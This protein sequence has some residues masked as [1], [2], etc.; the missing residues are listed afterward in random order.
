M[1]GVKVQSLFWY[2]ILGTFK[3]SCIFN[4]TLIFFSLSKYFLK[5]RLNQNEFMKSSI[6]SCYFGKL[7]ISSIHSDLIWPLVCCQSLK[8]E[9]N[10]F[11]KTNEKS[12]QFNSL[13]NAYNV[14]IISWYCSNIGRWKNLGVPVVKGGQ[15]LPPWLK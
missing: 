4:L 3:S 5:V 15:N 12:R 7:K 6:F 8:S 2:L 13:H 1:F 9:L 11:L 14:L 10:L